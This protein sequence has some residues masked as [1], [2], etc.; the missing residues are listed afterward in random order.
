MQVYSKLVAEAVHS[1]LAEVEH[2]TLA[3]AGKQPQVYGDEDDTHIGLVRLH[4]T[5]KK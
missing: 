2:S 3:V 1:T 5:K 4:Y